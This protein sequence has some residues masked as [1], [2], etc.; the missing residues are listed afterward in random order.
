MKIAVLKG[1]PSQP[2]IYRKNQEI[3]LTFKY[4]TVGP[5]QVNCSLI[6]YSRASACC[7]VLHPRVYVLE[8][9]SLNLTSLRGGRLKGKG[10]GVLGAPRVS[11]AL[12][13][14]PFPFKRLP[15]RL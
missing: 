9:V 14:F 12:T 6:A 11:L 5:F 1:R 2:G 4:G 3:R 13:P 7:H 15:R 8:P 10:K